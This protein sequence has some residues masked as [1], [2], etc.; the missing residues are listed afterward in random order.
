[1]L[2]AIFPDPS[3]LATFGQMSMAIKY[4]FRFTTNA[5]IERKLMSL[6]LGVK[7]K[8]EQSKMSK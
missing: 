3:P 1:M 4:Q 2:C 8:P 6:S 5:K 7:K